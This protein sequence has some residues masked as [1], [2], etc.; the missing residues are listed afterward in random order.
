MRRRPRL[1]ALGVAGQPEAI[2]NGRLFGAMDRLAQSSRL[3]VALFG[4]VGT[5]VQMFRITP[6]TDA[7]VG[8]QGNGDAILL[9]DCAAGL[10]LLAAQGTVA[11]GKMLWRLNAESEPDKRFDLPA[12]KKRLVQYEKDGHAS[13]DC[14]FVPGMRTTAM[15]TNLPGEKAPM[16]LAF[17]YSNDVAIDPGALVATLRRA[18]GQAAA[19]DGEREGSFLR[20]LERA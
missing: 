8:T 11:A 10:L 16:A 9:S 14:G 5:H 4:L 7:P 15:L 19:P 3:T 1:A 17:L 6:G 20:S 13:G 2:R 12:M 18:I